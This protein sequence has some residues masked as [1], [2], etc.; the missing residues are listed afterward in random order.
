MSKITT[1]DDFKQRV[2]AGFDKN[3]K[4][5]N[6]YGETHSKQLKAYLIESNQKVKEVGAPDGKWEKLDSANWYTNKEGKFQ[7]NFFLDSTRNRVWIVYSLLDA[8]TSDQAIEKWI[9]RTY[10]LDRCWLSRKHL[11]HWGEME[12]W[13][14]RG[15]GF[16]FTDGLFPEGEA[17]NFSLKAWYRS[18]RSIEGLDEIME[19]ATDKFAIHSSRWDKK[20]NGE[21]VIS[22]EWY[23]NGKATINRAED[24]DETFLS[25]SEMANRYSDSLIQ[26][27][28][29][30][31]STM[32][33]FEI[34]FTQEIDL[35]SFSTIVS[36]GTGEMNLWLV[37]TEKQSDFRRFKGIDLHTWDR[38]LL[39]IG[40]D[41]AY[42]TIPGK[43]CV[44][45]VP[46]MATIQGENI[47][48]KT[49]IYH[50]GVEIFA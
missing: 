5:L 23:S 12:S 45:A 43:G 31:D 38:V 4:S 18:N 25:I 13:D 40:L 30:R 9:D 46:R 37:E 21:V 24:V 17:G 29:L 33:A 47:A 50:D 3:E 44:N 19:I 15:F 35:E 48:G 20:A 6:L 8:E 41:Y 10:G 26:A 14:Q 11:L 16:K 28:E 1:L 27:T 39:D 7:N 32:G 22:S 34:D 2:Q 42:L 49:S 36:K